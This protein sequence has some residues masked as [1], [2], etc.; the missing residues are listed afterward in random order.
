MHRTVTRKLLR[1]VV[2][3]PPPL[4]TAKVRFLQ[5]SLPASPQVHQLKRL[6]DDTTDKM[7]SRLSAIVGQENVTVAEAVRSQHG[8]DEGPDK[9]SNPDIVVFASETA[10]VSEVRQKVYSVPCKG[11][12]TL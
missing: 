2:A 12:K 9:G 3:A 7:R 10:E 6:D 1:A 4:A 8:Q 5:T 11:A